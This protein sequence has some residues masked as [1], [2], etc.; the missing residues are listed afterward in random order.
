MNADLLTS[1]AQAIL[2]ACADAYDEVDDAPERPAELQ[3]TH[4][5]AVLNRDIIAV[6][7]TLVQRAAPF[8][9]TGIA[10]PHSTIV[11]SAEFAIECNRNGWPTANA[12]VGRVAFAKTEDIEAKAAQIAGDATT[13]FFYVTRL[14]AQGAL[15]PQHPTIG[16]GD[17]TLGQLR[18]VGPSGLNAGWRWTIQVKLTVP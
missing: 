7:W 9:Q 10:P 5:P 14:I 2:K 11:P 3:V 4:G 12:G 16:K 13:V 15:F 18:P 1:C 17:I 8:P 6:S